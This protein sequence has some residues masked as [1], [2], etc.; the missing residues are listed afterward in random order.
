[1]TVAEPEQL[2]VRVIAPVFDGEAFPHDAIQ[3]IQH[4]DWGTV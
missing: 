4:Q 1:M 2:G 3:G